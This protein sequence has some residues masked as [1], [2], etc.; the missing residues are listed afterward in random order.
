ML[1]QLRFRP[2]RKSAH[3][4]LRHNASWA[5]PEQILQGDCTILSLH[6]KAQGFAFLR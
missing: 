2:G 5:H 4:L 6:L 1:S 3:V